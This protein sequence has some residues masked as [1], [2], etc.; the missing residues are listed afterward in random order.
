MKNYLIINLMILK[1]TWKLINSLLN[2]TTRDSKSNI[3]KIDSVLTNNKTTIVNSF[4]KYFSEIG[5][6]L[7]QNIPSTNAGSSLCNSIDLLKDSIALIPTDCYEV[8]SVIRNIK[9]SASSGVD[10]IPIAAIKSVSKTLAPILATLINHSFLREY[11]QML[12]K[13]PK[14]PLYLRQG[15]NLY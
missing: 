15:T 10:M 1:K 7:A 13:F 14:S 6:S 5:P 8:E 2:K 3:F 9:S 4:N 11:F 12:L